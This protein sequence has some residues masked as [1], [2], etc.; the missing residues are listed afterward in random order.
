VLL[1]I[2]I[3]SSYKLNQKTSQQFYALNLKG[4]MAQ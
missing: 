1:I 2:R 4:V 3:V